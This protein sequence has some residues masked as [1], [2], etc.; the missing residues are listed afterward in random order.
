MAVMLSRTLSLGMSC[1]RPRP[2]LL[3]LVLVALALV[4][5]VATVVAQVAGD[6][7]PGFDIRSEAAQDP[8]RPGLT[9]LQVS[10]RDAAAKKLAGTV[11]QLRITYDPLLGT[12]H[13]VRS[14]RQLLTGKPPAGERGAKTV[15]RGFVAQHADLLLA[16][17]VDLQGCRIRR[18]AVTKHNGVHSLTYQQRLNGIDIFGAQLR[19]NVT[20]DGELIN[21]S[22]T[23][24]SRP[25]RL[26]VR[27]APVLTAAQAVAAA[28][29]NVGVELTAPL[30]AR[31][32]KAARGSAVEFVR[33]ADF[34]GAPSARLLYFPM[35]HV[36][37]RLVWVVVVPVKGTA[38]V[39]EIFVDAATGEV[40][41]RRNLT[42]Y[43][44][45]ETATYR[46]YTSDSPSPFSPGSATP[47]GFQPPE[48][49]RGLVTQISLDATASPDGWIPDGQN[50][51][52]GNNVDAHLDLN[53]NNVPDLP[54]PSGSPYRVFDFS[55]NLTQAPSAYRDASVTQL[56]YLCN[57]IHDR[58]YQL[59]FDEASGNFQTNNFGRGGA[60]N[61]PVQA[62]AQD[63]GSTD[64]A[65]FSTPGDGSSPR[66]QMY[67]FVGSN[68]D[69]DGSLDAEV[70][71]HEYVHGLSQRL[72]SDL[73]KLQSAG[74]GEGWGDF[75]ALALLAEPGDDPH[76]TFALGGYAT[77][78]LA[79]LT[80]NYYFG[81]RRFPYSTDMNKNPETFADID[82]S[83]IS[84]PPSI[85]RSPIISNTADEV[86]NIGEVWCTALWECRANLIDALGF[87]GNEL[88]LQLVT[89]GMK[90]SPSNP[91]LLQARDA[92]LQADTVNYGGAHLELL[93][94]G[95]A[96]RGM[97]VSARGPNAMRT[98]G[99][100]EAFDTWRDP[101]NIRD[102]YW[103]QITESVVIAFTAEDGTDYVLE[104]AD[105]GE[106]SDSVVWYT[107][108]ADTL[109]GAGGEATFADDL[110][111][112]PLTAA[113][114]FYRIKQA[115]A[116]DISRQTVGV[117][118][119]TLAASVSVPLN[120]I[121][122]PL[123]PDPDHASAREI[124]GQGAARQVPRTNFQVS[125]L[126]EDTGVISRMRYTFADSTVFTVL[127]GAEFDIVPGAGY[128]L[129]MGGGFTPAY[130]VRLT[131]YV[132][133]TAVETPL[134]K[135]G[136]NAQRWMAYSMPRPTTLNDLGLTAAVT[137]FGQ[138]QPTNRVRIIPHGLSVWTNYQYNGTFWYVLG[139]P[140]TPVNPAIACGT[141]IEFF[142]DGFPN[143]T[144]KLVSPTWYLDPPNE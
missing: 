139:T 77:Y 143:S 127:T 110:T 112:N 1:A 5:P 87:A 98:R 97:G 114:R 37:V 54:R 113:F 118:E 138:W 136:I 83:Q 102:V 56:F 9:P 105:A 36:E 24:L 111:V 53:N 84:F 132:P 27:A 62:D 63:G 133:E 130:K 28:A 80:D 39:Y 89:D 72:H 120:F 6:S 107:L 86:H 92:I 71:I 141:A 91:N 29:G 35:S 95:F 106:Y 109:T 16:D 100:N 119:M 124:F 22:S 10:R 116:T 3:W 46:V 137:G 104:R 42:S 131:G 33:T 108:P 23:L 140:G 94:D 79:G 11:E 65:N 88:M 129:I 19:A 8:P 51:T 101:A 70:V 123:I 96:K 45:A 30:E 4:W 134:T 93:W 68:P 66:M 52:L 99:V 142:R 58:L 135:V 55:L 67:I 74:M 44:G 57:W 128:E 2:G 31:R 15:V 43:A 21:I 18:D 69:R 85:P 121:S 26:N 12:P 50:Q 48:V 49:P 82:P 144:D 61:D 34:A 117:F 76:G 14:T 25:G 78:Q 126:D 81:I 38:D 32:G 13:F 47:N 20:R 64:N 73:W 115:D 41:F 122:T 90:L 125:D 60:G 103:D 59:G 7:R 17:E 40:L 75:Y